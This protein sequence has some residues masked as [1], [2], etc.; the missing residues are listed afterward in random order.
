ML[1]E[2]TPS[3]YILPESIIPVSRKSQSVIKNE[4]ITAIPPNDLIFFPVEVERRLKA[5]LN[6]FLIKNK[7]AEK[8][9]MKVRKYPTR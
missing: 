5:K 7:V 2:I 4:R 3:T 8:D 1:A 9:N 6:G